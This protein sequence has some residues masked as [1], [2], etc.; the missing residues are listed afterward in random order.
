MNLAKQ[1]LYRIIPGVC[2]AC[3]GRSHRA[4][5]LCR[6][7]EADLPWLLNACERCGLPLQAAGDPCLAC[8]SKPPPWERTIA[9]FS[10]AF[11]VDQLIQQFKN[12]QDLA[13]GKV[14]AR[15]LGQHIMRT[16]PAF[17]EG[18]GERRTLLVP[19]PLHPKKQRSRGFNQARQVAAMLAGMFNLRLDDRHLIRTRS[20]ADQKLLT[21]P[22]RRKNVAG[23]FTLRRAFRGERIIL[24]EDVV[25]TGATV[26]EM[27]NC[28]LRGGAGSVAVVAVARTPTTRPN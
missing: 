21:A 16:D 8:H 27:T 28:L 26:A 13:C 14:L 2:I 3:G 15:L 10:Y 22:E 9:A 4:I 18:D 11:P 1:F 20:T 19:T 12:R 24:V 17:L 6:G 7:C 5:D 23:A 25:T